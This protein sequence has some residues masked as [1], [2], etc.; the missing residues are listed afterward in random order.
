VGPAERGFQLEG[1]G[2]LTLGPTGELTL[3]ATGAVMLRF[4]LPLADGEDLHGFGSLPDGPGSRGQVREMQFRL[5]PQSESTLNEVHVPVP[6]ALYPERN[7]GFFAEEPRVGAFDVGAERADRV[8]V[9][10]A[11][12]SL[13]LVPYGGTPFQVLDGYTARTGRPRVPPMWAFAPFQWRN[14]STDGAEVV[15]DARDLRS[16]GIPG[17]C[18]WIDNPWQTGYNTFTFESGRFPDAGGLVAELEALGFHLMVWSTPYVNVAP[19]TDVDYAEAAAADYLVRDYAGRVVDFP[20]QDGPGAMVDFSA[21]GATDWWRERIG[22]VTALGLRGFKLDFGE[23]LVP[24]IGGSR[25]RLELAGGG[26]EVLHNLYAGLYH[27][28]YLGALPEGDGFLLTRAGAYGT[29][30]QT[31]CIWPGDLDNDFSRHDAGNVGGLPTAVSLMVSLS[32]SGFPFFGSDIGGFRDGPPTGESLIRWAEYAALGT[33]MQL[34]GGG[35]R[36]SSHNPW[37]VARYGPEALPIYQ[38]YSR[39]HT[40]LF[41][42]LYTHA[43]EA[44]RSGRPV[45]YAAALVVPRHPYED[46]FFLGDAL[47]VAPVV[48]EAATT[49]SVTLPPGDWL[50]FWTGE[51]A[52]GA[53]TV[54]APLDTLPLWRRVDAMVPLLAVPIDTF[55]PATEPGVVT[56]A[57]AGDRLRVLLALRAQSSFALWDGGLLS[58]EATAAGATLSLSPGTTHDD[59]RFELDWEGAPPTSATVPAATSLAELDACAAPG[60]WWWDP[61]SATAYLRLAGSGTATIS[62]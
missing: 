28:A 16:H 47:Y 60:C 32:A 44:G 8:L 62:R 43:L 15:Q 11:T 17:S 33:I 10:F 4:V 1:G 46:A 2:L 18:L 3:A 37:D 38:R 34:G 57:A 49:R 29:Q 9:T 6:L 59:V 36:G 14:D 27:E 25:L 58:A 23:E 45:T 19:P 31:T 55:L 30:T 50:D 53:V 26:N 42:Y 40:D 21:P 7:L 39:L 5:E 22:R 12:E 35:G 52:S 51:P 48:E 56:F 54:P 41:P 24:E 61:A 20:W 13:R